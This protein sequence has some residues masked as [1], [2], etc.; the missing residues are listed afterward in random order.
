MANEQTPLEQLKAFLNKL[1]QFESEDLDFGIYKI[2]HYKRDEIR[3]FIDELLVN[4]VKEQLQTLTET[5]VKEAREALED[6]KAEPRIR[7]WLEAWEK[8]DE[9]RQQIYE[10]DNKED[11]RKYRKLEKQIKEAEV[12][13]DTESYIYNH[14]TRFFSR[15][16]DKGDFI[17]KRRFGKNEKY[18]VPYNGEETHF[19]WANHDQYYIKSS[20]HFQQFA[21]KVPHQEGELTVN[22]KLT[23]ADVEQGNVKAEEDKYFVLSQKAPEWEGDE[24]LTIYFEFRPLSEEE[25]NEVGNQ[26]KQDK[27]NENAA[28]YLQEQLQHQPIAHR[29]W[30]TN[31]KDQTLLLQR[32]NHYTRKN[33]YDFFIHK[34]LKGFLQRELDFYIKSEL[35]HVD[36]LYVLESDTHFDRIRQNFKAVKVFKQI[37]DTIIDFLA[38]IEDF[39]KKLWEKQKFVLN[40][41]WVIT[42]D[43]LVEYVGEEEA[44]PILADVVAN[45]KQLQ[46]WKDLFGKDVV[47]GNGLKIEDLKHD[48]YYWKKLPIDSVNFDSNFKEKLLNKL[49]IN[50][51]FDKYYDGLIMHSENYQGINLILSQHKNQIKSIYIDPPYNSPHSEILYKNSFKHSSWLTMMQN[52]IHLGKKLLEAND[53]VHVVA[54]DE[55][56]QEYLG[57]L[58]GKEFGEFK[59]TCVTIVHNPSGQQGDNFSFSH[60]YAYFTYPTT[61]RQINLK[62]REENT[63]DIRNFRD[64]TGE[65]SKREAAKNCF[66]PIY[67]KDGKIWGFGEVCSEDY[68]PEG[69]N[70]I[71]NDLIA[72]YPIDP[73]GIERKWRFARQTVEQIRGELRANFIKSRN[74]WDIQRVKS[75]FNYKTVWHESKY[76]A[77]N[78]G[79][80]LLNNI[81][82]KEIFTYPKSL[83]TVRDSLDASLNNDKNS[84][85]VDYFAGSGTTFHA[86]QLL[87]SEDNG[88][89]KCILIEQGDY[90][91]S[92]LIPRIKKVA[93]T[94]EWKDGYPKDHSMNGLG[95]F[96]KYQRLEQYEEA[97]ENISFNASEETQQKALEF[98]DYMPKY[99]L[100]FETQNSQTLVNTDAMKDPWDYRLRVWDGYTYDAEQ[101]VDLVETFN[102]LIGLHL[103]QFITKELNSQ[104]Y[105]FIKGHDN[106]DTRILVVW[107]KV[108]NWK[109]EDFEVDGNTLK[110]ELPNWSY[111]QLYI[112]DQA[113]LPEGYSYT[114]VEE[115]FKHKMVP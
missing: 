55:N 78:H 6:L 1:F 28:G 37:A 74:C 73:N 95:V 70:E 41:E 39:Q 102:Y 90:T 7:K 27:L 66:Y 88:K 75:K 16:Y 15:Y 92:S 42:I 45:Q 113:H 5:E 12:S 62:T 64:V 10:E 49:S 52:R 48:L 8:G 34:D 84:I 30:E 82:G 18:V 104:K 2:L 56:E 43:R 23:E 107:R 3:K 51:C 114:P 57:I 59:N 33:Q 65:E 100:E 112:N 32:L 71:E 46:E 63:S 36:D 94:F 68:H 4:R 60:E 40:T 109:K 53:G 19:Y 13:Q 98:K 72:V 99:F 24:E 38:Q 35:V 115:V 21:F 25:K 26:R 47:N 22:F 111:D 91:Y 61:G 17:S 29:L 76:F 83:Y 81:L 105:Q 31:D 86:T 103:E 97:L 50:E 89:R 106:N 69:I 67:V 11:I 101:A 79:T 110:E 58:L 85:V 20:E 9:T 93:Y 108:K 44:K 54:I 96:F 87:N 77:N 14:L 80:Q